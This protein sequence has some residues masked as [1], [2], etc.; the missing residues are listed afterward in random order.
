MFAKTITYIDFDGDQCSEKYYFN[1]TKAECMDLELM[2][3]AE[4]GLAAYLKQFFRKDNPVDTRWKPFVDFV[5]TFVEKAYGV[6]NGKSFIKTE[7]KLLEFKTSE[8][9]SELIMELLSKPEALEEFT[10]KTMPA[11]SDEALKAAI[12]E[13]G[14]SGFI[15]T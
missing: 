12:A 5:K 4:G 1:L 7:E 3:E 8:A 9:Y 11:V 15:D 10:R 2:Y 13:N 6:R 14:L